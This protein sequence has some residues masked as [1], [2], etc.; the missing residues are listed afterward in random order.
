MWWFI[1]CCTHEML[2]TPPATYTSP[3]PAITRCAAIA[4]VCSPEEQKRLIVMPDTV[5]GRSASSAIWR[6]MLAPVAPSG[7][8][9][10]MSTSSTVAGSM[11]ARCTA[12]LTAWPPSVAPWVML[13]APFQLLVSGVR[14]VETITALVMFVAPE[15]V[16]C[17]AFGGQLR[18]QRRRLPELRV[19]ARVLREPLHRLDDV[20]QAHLVGVEHRP[21]AEDREAVARDVGDV[22][23]AGLCRDAVLEDARAFVHQCEHEALHDF[24]VADLPWSNA[25]FLA[26]RHDH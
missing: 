2:S 16:E 22:D 13:K 21:A 11:P 10:P 24:V 23:V 12:C 17:L 14:A 6:A 4:I 15:S 19:V 25:Q 7:L 1:S 8:A 18:E 26:V 5:I 3:S 9:Q 20:E